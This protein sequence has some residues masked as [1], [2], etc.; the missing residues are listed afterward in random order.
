[1]AS[2]GFVPP[3]TAASIWW[4][5]GN[6]DVWQVWRNDTNPGD[7][8]SDNLLESGNADELNKC[9]SLYVEGTKQQDG[10]SYPTSTMNQLLS[11]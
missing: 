6:F 9:L 11:G 8:V 10:K 7:P 2:K 5:C 3:N 1:M 4:A